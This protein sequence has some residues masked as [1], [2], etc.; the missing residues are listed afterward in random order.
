[1][2]KLICVGHSAHWLL[3][4]SPAT[5]SADA[6]SGRFTL[7][8]YIWNERK[9]TPSR[10]ISDSALSSWS[11]LNETKLINF[12][13]SA[14]FP[15]VIGAVDWLSLHFHHVGKSSSVQTPHLNTALCTCSHLG[16]WG[17]KTSRQFSLLIERL[18]K[19]GY[20][21]P[22]SRPTSGAGLW[23]IS[24]ENPQ[25]WVLP[26]EASLTEVVFLTISFFHL[27][28][29]PFAHQQVKVVYNRCLLTGLVTRSL[30]CFTFSLESKNV[31]SS[32][33][34]TISDHCLFV[35]QRGKVHYF[36]KVYLVIYVFFCCWFWGFSVGCRL[37]ARCFL[38]R[39]REHNTLKNEFVLAGVDMFWEDVEKHTD[40]LAC[41]LA[42]VVWGHRECDAVKSHLCFLLY[43]EARKFTTSQK[44]GHIYWFFFIFV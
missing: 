16:N 6:D 12:Y 23:L 7:R 15:R 43:V 18:S 37:T 20:I 28:S 25:K 2:C 11:W 1:M 22:R 4:F 13:A 9:Q 41:G 3:M 26:A 31:V 21:G 19:S 35:W 17:C 27:L 34:K 24:Q 8:R 33:A 44:S 42:R 10:H 38:P 32:F 39:K 36:N 30:Y 29:L 40:L 5:M 14:D